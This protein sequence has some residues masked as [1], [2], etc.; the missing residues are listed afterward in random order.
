MGLFDKSFRK[1][2]KSQRDIIVPV[3]AGAA[4]VVGEAI[5]KVSK[6][7][8]V[9]VPFFKDLETAQSFAKKLPYYAPK[10]GLRKKTHCYIVPRIMKEGN[11]IVAVVTGG[12][13][14]GKE[15]QMVL[16]LQGRYGSLDGSMILA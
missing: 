6:D 1:D 11:E 8:I 4:E 2:I 12:A 5:K 13:I 10:L 7:G 16:D 3:Q 14:T 15:K 9:F